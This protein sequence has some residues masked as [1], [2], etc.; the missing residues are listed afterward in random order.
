M[1]LA[2]VAGPALGRD[3]FENWITHSSFEDFASGRIADG[4]TNLYIARSGQLEM[5]HRWDLNNDGFLD[6]L[7]IQDHNPLENV[8]CPGLLGQ[9]GEG[10]NRYCPR[11][12]AISRWHGC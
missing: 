1:I 3:E 10:R 6:L 2:V 12:P 5:T 9:E 8:G 11:C 4:G 7:V